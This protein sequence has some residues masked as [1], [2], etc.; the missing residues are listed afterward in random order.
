MPTLRHPYHLAKVNV[1]NRYTYGF[2]RTPLN[3]C[4]HGLFTWHTTFLFLPA[5]RSKRGICLSQPVLYQTTKPILK[6]F[7]P[8][9]SPII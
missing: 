2:I 4:F 3:D 9:G 7:R 5:R 6:L 8:S 1:Y